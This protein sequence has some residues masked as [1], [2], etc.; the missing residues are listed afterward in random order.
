MTKVITYNILNELLCKISGFKSDKEYLDPEYRYNLLVVKLHEWIKEDTIICLQ[1]ISLN[2]YCKLQTFFDSYDYCFIA[3]HYGAVY[4]NYMGV[5]IAYPKKT[6]PL[7]IIISVPATL[8]KKY[9]TYTESN[10][11][12]TIIPY[13]VKNLYQTLY[14]E[15]VT[16][17]RTE[18][19]ILKMTS[20]NWNRMITIKFEQ[21]Y[22]STYHMPCKFKDPELMSVYLACCLERCGF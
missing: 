8:A 18:N 14:Q 19:D 20:D 9:I 12:S 1:E 3:T 7:E 6:K 13:F 11:I 15:I 2:M 5:G 21:L 17:T 16:P 4:N 10:Y 22:V